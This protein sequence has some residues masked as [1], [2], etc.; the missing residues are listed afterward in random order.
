MKRYLLLEA[1]DDQELAEIDWFHGRTNFFPTKN[2]WM[3]MSQ[4]YEHIGE[5]LVPL[6]LRMIVTRRA[7]DKN[8]DG[9]N[10]MENDGK[11]DPVVEAVANALRD[12]TEK[13]LNEEDDPLVEHTLVSSL[14]IERTKVGMYGEKYTAKTTLHS[15]PFIGEGRTEQEAIVNLAHEI[16]KTDFSDFHN[17]E[18]KECKVL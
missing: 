10:K 7:E 17:Y 14:I 2:E 3:L 9:V 16:G 18:M 1:D 6:G 11:K 12:L 5:M 15:L 8:K 4:L 13:S